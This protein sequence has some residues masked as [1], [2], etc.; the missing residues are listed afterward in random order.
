VKASD[1][2]KLPPL[3]DSACY[4]FCQ[5][6]LKIERRSPALVDRIC[7]KANGHPLY[8][9]YLIEYANL[10]ATDDHL[11]DFPVL[12][13]PIEEYYQGIWAKLLLDSHAV[14]LLAVMA[15][16]RWG[17]SLEDFAKALNPAEEANFVAVM[18]R[19]RHLLDDEESTAI[20]H[21]S[22]ASFI[23]DQ[24][25]GIDEA[26]Y[27]RLAKFCLEQPGVRYCAL[28]RV[29]HLSRAGDV[30]VFGECNQA[31]FDTAVTLGVE[32]DAL[33]ADVDAVVK[34]AA[35]EAPADE[36]FRLALLAQ[37]ISFRYD[38]LF[39]QSARCLTPSEYLAV[40]ER[41][42]LHFWPCSLSG[43]KRYPVAR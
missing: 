2:F 5:M 40:G 35:I 18:S 37:R 3:S 15:R 14:N 6:A 34:R 27:R 30:G 16:L 43:F 11:D 7:Q 21:A 41:A 28:N 31:W 9:R 10:Q 1:V 26:A 8:L 39:A 38:T 19:I 29:F 25:S 4:R 22:F 24:T 33:I 36:F 13:G 20:Y 12:K 17:L 42:K 23:I 32:P